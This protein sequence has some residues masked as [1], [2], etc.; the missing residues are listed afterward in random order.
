[1]TPGRDP[2]ETAGIVLAVAL[3]LFIVCVLAV[4]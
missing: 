1:M 4:R 3:A 2:W